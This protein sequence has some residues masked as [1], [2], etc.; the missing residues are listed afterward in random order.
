MKIEKYVFCLPHATKYASKKIGVRPL[1]PTEIQTLYCIRRL[2]TATNATIIQYLRKYQNNGNDNAV[3]FALRDL[4][5]LGLI[6][7]DD[8][9]Y[10]LNFSG[11]EWMSLVRRY[12]VNIR[13]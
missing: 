9:K 4:T 13:L 6:I 3:S 11:R 7:K 12:M 2:G 10:T 1:R 5:A 8:R